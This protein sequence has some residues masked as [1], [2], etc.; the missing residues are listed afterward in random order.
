M[1]EMYMHLKLMPYLLLAVCTCALGEPWTPAAATNMVAWYDAS[2]TNTLTETGGVVTEWYDR[3]TNN[4]WKLT[5][6]N[7]PTTGTRTINDLNVLDFDGALDRGTN[8]QSF[9]GLARVLG[10]AQR[11][12]E[13]G[14]GAVFSE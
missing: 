3:S 10:G 8:L 14:Q 5:S 1:Y 6:A 13:I 9:D 7:G 2:E 4:F 11:E 12:Q